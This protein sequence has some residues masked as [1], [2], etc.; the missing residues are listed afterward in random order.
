MRAFC[1][2]RSFP[3]TT[4]LPRFLKPDPRYQRGRWRNEKIPYRYCDLCQTHVGGRKLAP[5]DET[6]PLEFFAWVIVEFR[7]PSKWHLNGQNG[8]PSFEGR[9]DG[10]A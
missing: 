2:S 5:L 10:G 1:N 8:F 6:L 7:R 4:W 9:L 3:R